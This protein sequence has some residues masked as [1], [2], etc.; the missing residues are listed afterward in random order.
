MEFSKKKLTQE[1][2]LQM[3]ASPMSSIRPY[4]LLSA[5]AYLFMKMNGKFVGIKGPLDFFTPEELEKLK[6]FETLYFTDFV[7]TALPFQSVA[8]SIRSLLLWDPAVLPPTPYEMSDAVLRLLGKVWWKDASGW[9]VI[10]P[11]FVSIFVDELCDAL[12]TDLLRQLRDDNLSLCD[13][14]IFKSSIAVFLALHL[15]HNEI[16]YLNKL[17]AD[18]FQ[19][20]AKKEKIQIKDQDLNYLYHEWV[21]RIF[22][23]NHKKIQSAYLSESKN[24]SSM[25]LLGRMTRIKN[26]LARGASD[27]PVPTIYGARGVI[28]A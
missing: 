13:E 24:S 15:A 18:V 28:D 16:T 19:Q 9:P 3:R 14:A 26:V 10:E 17:R 12:P 27:G 1:S 5:P 6:P 7:D 11:Y 4:R 25:K 21:E 22:S 2:A 23:L 20:V 8:R